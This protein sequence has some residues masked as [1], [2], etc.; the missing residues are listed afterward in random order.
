[1]A[2][3]HPCLVESVWQDTCLFARAFQGPGVPVEYIPV[4]LK[5]IV[6]KS[7]TSQIAHVLLATMLRVVGL[8]LHSGLQGF[9]AKL[10]FETNSK[11][12]AELNKHEM[13]IVC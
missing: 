4:T 3:R 13:S 12:T 2:A 10:S 5:N 7:F 8:S 6:V 11:R 1:M 9:S